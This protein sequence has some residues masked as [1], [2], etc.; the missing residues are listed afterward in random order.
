MAVTKIPQQGDVYWIDL[1]SISGQEMLK[2]HR[3]MV[4]TP[5]EINALGVSMLVPITGPGALSQKMG[6]VVPLMG[7]DTLEVAVC[8]QI[9]SFDLQARVQ[10]GLAGYVES[11]E[12]SL[13]ADIVT[14]VL[15]VIDPA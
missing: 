12:P 3:F 8:N 11:L 9:R 4:I 10:K 1:D 14:R 2:K 13:V 15:S 7:R 6:L 5:E